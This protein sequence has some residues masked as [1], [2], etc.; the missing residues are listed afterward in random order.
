MSGPR[1]QKPWCAHPSSSTMPTP[2]RTL[3]PRAPRDLGVLHDDA[4]KPG[5]VEHALAEL[6]P[7]DVLID[8]ARHAAEATG[9][10]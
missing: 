3:G 4:D 1:T 6:R 8:E 7:G 2:R 9:R 5:A 10:L